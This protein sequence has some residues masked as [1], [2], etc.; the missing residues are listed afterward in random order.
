MR[1]KEQKEVHDR[2]DADV[3]GDG[4]VY[5]IAQVNSWQGLC[6]KGSCGENKKLRDWM[7]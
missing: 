7:A 3:I 1:V 6:R 4:S 5:L 2:R